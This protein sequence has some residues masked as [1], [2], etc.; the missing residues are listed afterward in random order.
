METGCRDTWRTEFLPLLPPQR[1]S[2]EPEPDDTFPRDLMGLP[3]TDTAT[4][5]FEQYVIRDPTFIGNPKT[6][7]PIAWWNDSREVFPSLHLYAF[8]TLAIPAISAKYNR[9]FSS[10]KKLIKPERNRLAED[11]I[12]TSECLKN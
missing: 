3:I 7:N 9:V 6:F 10:T 12:E 5:E 11:I 8:D 1:Q 4:D 2:P